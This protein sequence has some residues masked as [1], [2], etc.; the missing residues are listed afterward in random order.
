VNVLAGGVAG[1]SVLQP[2][3]ALGGAPAE[4][5]DA[6]HGRAL[7]LLAGPARGISVGDWE[8][9][10]LEVPGVPV[11]RAATVPGHLPELGCWAAPG[12]VTVVVLPACGRPPVP[13]AD[14]LAAVSRYLERRRPLTTEL[15]VVG[16]HYVPVT[17]TATLHAARRVSGLPAAAQAALDAFFDPL[18]GGPD[19]TGWPFGR[20]VLKSDLVDILAGLPGVAYVDGLGIATPD[21]PASCENLALCPTDLVASQAHRFTVVED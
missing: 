12:A 5:L 15:R 11:A 1:L 2:F 8:T 21:G 9:L 16:P 7:A 3:A 10:A 19:G 17:V 6:A 4:S 18:T 20:G 14:F 13:G